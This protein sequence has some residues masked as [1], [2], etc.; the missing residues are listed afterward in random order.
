MYIIVI[1]AVLGQYIFIMGLREK[2]YMHCLI[3]RFVFGLSDLV[4]I[5]QNIIMCTWF[6]PSQLPVAFS[7]LLFMVKLVR[8]INDNTAS[9]VFN[10]YQDLVIFFQIG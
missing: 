10:H 8:A 6:T 3:S 7:L 5:M 9:M 4:T 1:S 2:N